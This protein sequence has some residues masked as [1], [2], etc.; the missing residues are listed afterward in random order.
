MDDAERH[1]WRILVRRLLPKK[2]NIYIYIYTSSLPH[3]TYTRTRTHTHTH[4]HFFS[5]IIIFS[6]TKKEQR[7]GAKQLESFSRRFCHRFV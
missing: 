2:T 4:T 1:V 7:E 3:S 6:V 5:S